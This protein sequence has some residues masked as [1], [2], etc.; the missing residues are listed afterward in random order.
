VVRARGSLGSA[1][2]SGRCWTRC[3]TRAVTVRAYTRPGRRS[4]GAGLAGMRWRGGGGVRAVRVMP[5]VRVLPVA[6]RRAV[7]CPCVASPARSGSR[8]PA[9]PAARR[10]SRSAP[11]VR[12]PHDRGRGGARRSPTVRDRRNGSCSPIGEAR[13]GGRGQGGRTPYELAEGRGNGR[14][15][16][17]PRAVAAARHGAVRCL[18]PGTWGHRAVRAEVP[19]GRSH[20][21]ISFTRRGRAYVRQRARGAGKAPG[22]SEPAERLTGRPAAPPRPRP[23]VRSPSGTRP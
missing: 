13:V 7:C 4:S 23:L 17:R 8:S 11:T 18:T 6:G 5:A 2:H 20:R 21:S 9:H 3:L 15:L 10:R 1:V 16:L 22:G 12:V 14:R 19:S